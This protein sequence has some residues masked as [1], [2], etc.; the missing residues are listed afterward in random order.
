MGG[1]E[2]SCLFRPRT[3]LFILFGLVGEVRS[4]LSCLV[5]SCL[6]LTCLSWTCGYGWVWVVN[7][8]R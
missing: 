1:L 7:V 4:D 2:S 5:L 8:S 3:T 6:V